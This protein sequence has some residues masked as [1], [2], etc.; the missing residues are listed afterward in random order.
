M[1]GKQRKLQR[2]V[3]ESYDPLYRLSR[4]EHRGYSFKQCMGSV[5]WPEPARLSGCAYRK[6]VQS[7]AQE[8]TWL[9]SSKPSS[10]S[11]VMLKTRHST[12]RMRPRCHIFNQAS[13]S[14]WSTRK[15]DIMP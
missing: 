5:I 9:R 6:S 1:R 15:G 2:C 12:S 11:F 8:D 13:V 4:N 10:W 3:R 14:I 7:V